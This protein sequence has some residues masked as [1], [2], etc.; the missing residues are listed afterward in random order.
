MDFPLYLG[1][2]ECFSSLLCLKL[3]LKKRVMDESEK[4]KQTPAPPPQRNPLQGPMALKIYS[5]ERN[6]QL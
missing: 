4:S 2:F 5:L 3:L 6:P 1:Y